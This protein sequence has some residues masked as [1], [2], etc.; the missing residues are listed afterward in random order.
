[1]HFID[2]HAHLEWP[3]ITEQ[4]HNMID[5]AITAGI[6]HIVGSASRSED[7]PR[8]MAL[9]DKFPSVV[10]Y[11]IGIHPEYCLDPSNS[12]Q[13][14][15]KFFEINSQRFVGI[16]EIG[17]DF[18][19]HKDSANR[20]QT[21]VIFRDLLHFAQ[22]KQQPIVIHCRYAEKQAL[23]ILRDFHDLPGV[24]LHCFGG[25][26]KFIE[27]GLNR[28]YFFT[29]PTSIIYKKLHQ[30]LAARIP[31][32]RLLLETDAPFLPPSPEIQTNEPRYVIKVAEEISRIKNLPLADIAKAT[33]QNAM[34]F[35][36]L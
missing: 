11:T 36:K 19:V 26:P 13:E 28:G 31:L 33:T 23:R 2:A 14:F 25:A 24:L 9:L 27:E 17:L 1:M 6:T 10:H 4:V 32:E 15:K 3:T 30:D 29:I 20:L 22:E 8:C 21:E 16:G 18:L 34:A 5:R 7:I 12:I 35:F